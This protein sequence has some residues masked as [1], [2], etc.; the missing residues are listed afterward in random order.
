MKNLETSPSKVNNNEV[1]KNTERKKV[2]KTF[3]EKIIKAINTDKHTKD[4]ER[5]NSLRKELGLQEEI[6]FSKE[7][8]EKAELFIR[9]E[10]A[11][12]VAEE[13]KAEIEKIEAFPIKDSTLNVEKKN[14]QLKAAELDI[15][16]ARRD[17]FKSSESIDNKTIEQYREYIKQNPKEKIIGAESE[18]IKK[19]INIKRNFYLILIN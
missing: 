12:K 7:Q 10:H 16:K 9:A 6:K 17:I 14:I 3:S 5:L 2:K 1:L 13:K 19:L 4:N 8:I 15:L 11:L 18:K